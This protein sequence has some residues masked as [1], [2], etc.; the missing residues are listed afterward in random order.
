MKPSHLTGVLLALGAATI[1]GAVPNFARLAFL[2]GVPALENVF[3][4]T[5]TVAVVLA[6][7]AV[8]RGESFRIRAEAWSSFLYQCLATLMVSACYLASVQFLPVTLSV[9]IFYLFPV[10]ILLAAPLAEGRVPGFARLGVA[11][12]GFSGLAVSVGPAFDQV[13]VLGLVLAFL[14]AVG[15]MMQFF[16]GRM[17]SRHLTP[18]A[19]GSLVHIAIWP[20]MLCLALGFGGNTLRLIDG[21]G[22]T[23]SLAFLAVALVSVAYVGGYFLHMSSVRAAPSS[24]VA[25]YFNLEPIVSTMLA[26]FILGEA[27]SINQWIG[28]AMVFA[29]LV[30]SGLLPEK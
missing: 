5:S 6:I 17:L 10:L 7:V 1:Y 16:S 26:V 22:L 24:V 4:R 21:Q 18:A 11:L 27:M 30:I 28:G 3:Y 8:V 13:S 2:N 25:P 23:G 20:I 9:I 12:L 14:G 15:C 19:F 29:A